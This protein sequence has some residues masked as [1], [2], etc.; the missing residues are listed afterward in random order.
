LGWCFSFVLQGKLSFSNGLAQKKIK[1]RK[2]KKKREK[3]RSHP[4]DRPEDRLERRRR[5]LRHAEDGK[6]ALEAV[7]DV[8]FAVARGLHRGD[9]A[10]FY[11]CKIEG[12]REGKR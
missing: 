11:F 5:G 2:K 9:V 4:D 7:G 1:E 12:E 3:T 10:V 8:V 6:V